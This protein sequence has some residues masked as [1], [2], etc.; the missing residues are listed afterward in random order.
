[1]ISFSGP[2]TCSARARRSHP[3]RGGTARG[4]RRGVP[5]GELA[6]EEAARAE[7]EG[8]EHRV[9]ARGAEA[10]DARA[11]A[12]LGHELRRARRVAHGARAVH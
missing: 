11:L 9:E 8:D 5:A 4:S 1:M 6:R 7:G 10:V 12:A 2:R 3:S